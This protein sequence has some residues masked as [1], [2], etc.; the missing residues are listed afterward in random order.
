ML[1]QVL[2]ENKVDVARISMGEFYSEENTEAFIEFVDEK[3]LTFIP[4]VKSFTVVRTGPTS[5]LVVVTFGD[6]ETVN[7][8]FE[9]RQA[10]I[11]ESGIELKDLF[12]LEGSVVSNHTN[13]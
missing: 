8:T 6:L 11:D 4:E 7:D 13:K 10:M 12:H 1:V 9:A 5:I 2:R 3:C